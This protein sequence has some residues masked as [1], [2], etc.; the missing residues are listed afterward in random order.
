WS[1][2]V[3]L[4]DGRRRDHPA[5]RCAGAGLLRAPETG[6][7]Q[8]RSPTKEP[9]PR[10]LPHGERGDFSGRLVALDEPSISALVTPLP[11]GEGPGVGFL[12]PLSVRTPDQ[13]RV[14]TE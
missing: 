11:V 4:R 13:G 12:G 10:P 14:L 8:R 6:V 9:H 2:T 5:V 7:A 3:G 1:V